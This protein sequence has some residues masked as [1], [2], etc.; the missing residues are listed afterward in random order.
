VG[1]SERDEMGGEEGK[2]G[3]GIGGEKGYDGPDAASAV[4]E[5]ATATRKVEK[6]MMMVEREWWVEVEGKGT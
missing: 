1:G 5:K 2:G 6:R 3:D 4:V